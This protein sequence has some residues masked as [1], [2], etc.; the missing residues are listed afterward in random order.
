MRAKAYDKDVEELARYIAWQENRIKD[1]KPTE[2]EPIDKTSKS[3]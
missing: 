3:A 2:C 1:W